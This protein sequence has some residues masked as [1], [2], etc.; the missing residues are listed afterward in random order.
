MTYYNDCAYAV[1]H[2]LT[3]A[4]CKL[5]SR[6]A[7][8][9]TCPQQVMFCLFLCQICWLKLVVLMLL[10]CWFLFYFSLWI[11]YT[12]CPFS[13]Y[14]CVSDWPAYHLYLEMWYLSSELRECELCCA[15]TASIWGNSAA[16]SCGGNWYFF[17]KQ[18]LSAFFLSGMPVRW[19]YAM[20]IFYWALSLLFVICFFPL[21]WVSA[22]LDIESED[23]SNRLHFRPYQSAFN[24]SFYSS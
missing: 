1:Y 21:C 15:L 17:K 24:R 5:W 19:K 10:K 3:C 22:I 13:P 16:S 2:L 12:V 7:L 18:K 8:G 23:C 6:A 4:C 11:C 20:E 14:T 9:I